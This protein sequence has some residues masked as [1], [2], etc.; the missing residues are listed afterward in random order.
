MRL[1]Q[2]PTG[3][4]WQ[5]YESIYQGDKYMETG[6]M[7]NCVSVV[8][9]GGKDV[10][11]Y[12]G[13]GGLEAVNFKEIKSQMSDLP[14]SKMIVVFGDDSL[15]TIKGQAQAIIKQQGFRNW[16]WELYKSTNA[17]IY[18]DGKVL[19]KHSQAPVARL[20]VFISQFADKLK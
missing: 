20:R 1:T 19:D 4:S 2:K 7:G 10:R 11:G 18:R 14:H 5:K 8:A 16:Q 9:I 17:H 12:H 6:S 3:Q 13:S 15:D